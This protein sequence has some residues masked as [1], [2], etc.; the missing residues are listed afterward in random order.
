MSVALMLKKKCS[1]S[2]SMSCMFASRVLLVVS[3]EALFWKYLR[4][5]YHW[6][7]YLCG[8]VGYVSTELGGAKL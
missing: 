8:A 4:G 2:V 3:S 6:S 5:D 1:F 7:M